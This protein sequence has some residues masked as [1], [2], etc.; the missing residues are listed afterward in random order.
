MVVHKALIYK[1]EGLTLAAGVGLGGN[2]PLGGSF[3]LG[4]DVA[5]IQVTRQLVQP[6]GLHEGGVAG[7]GGPAPELKL[8]DGGIVATCFKLQSIKCKVNVRVQKRYKRGC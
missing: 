7:D 2:A 8:R 3:R 5:H 1:R 4:L 6:Q